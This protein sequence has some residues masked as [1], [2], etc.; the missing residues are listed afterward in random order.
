[1]ISNELVRLRAVNSVVENLVASATDNQVSIVKQL[2]R[3]HPSNVSS[4]NRA[5]HSA[6]QA[7]AREG[8]ASCCKILIESGADVESVHKLG[9]PL[10]LACSNGNDE[11]VALLLQ[12]KYRVPQF[13]VGAEGQRTA[14]HGACSCGHLRS[15][16]LLL[17]KF[18]QDVNVKETNGRTPLH[19]VCE[20]HEPSRVL[21]QGRCEIIHLL[22]KRGASIHERD[23]AGNTP[24]LL[25]A[26]SG[27]ISLLQTCVDVGGNVLDRSRCGRSP[28]DEARHRKDTNM[29]QVLNVMQK[30]IPRSVVLASRFAG[31]NVTGPSPEVESGGDGGGGGMGVEDWS[32]L[33]LE[34]KKKLTSILPGLIKG[35][36]AGKEEKQQW[37]VEEEETAGENHQTTLV[38]GEPSHVG[39]EGELMSPD[40]SELVVVMQS[41]PGSRC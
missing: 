26:M 5:C 20:R 23:Q 27:C 16:Q 12:P 15:V 21:I 25:A 39:N 7:A 3:S 9:S 13:A 41:R 1:M 14:L 29:M 31:Y 18:P 33:Q 32:A 37:R 2:V 10:Y 36:R 11:V 28:I 34:E 38:N 40:A 24:I 35:G 4:L 6:L 30:K 19:L 22:M 8:H 17:K